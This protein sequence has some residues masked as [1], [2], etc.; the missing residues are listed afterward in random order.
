MNYRLGAFG[1]LAG[2][3]IVKGRGS[4]NLGWLDQTL[5]MKWVQKNIHL[6][7]GDPGLV[8]VFGE[9]AGASSILHHTTAYGGRGPSPPF[10]R[11]IPQSPA[12]FPQPEPSQQE[13]AYEALLVE[14][15]V[16]TSGELLA[17]NTSSLS[18]ANSR[19][20]RK[21]NY[22]QFI[23]GPTVDLF[24]N[25]VLPAQAL[26]GGH[27]FKEIE[28]MT[29]YNQREGL[30]FTPPYVQSDSSFGAYIQK[31]L[32]AASS[33]V[34]VQIEELYPTPSYSDS[35]RGGEPKARIDRLSQA[36]GDVA[37]NCNTYY[38]HQA[39]KKFT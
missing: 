11:A 19:T 33:D 16:E 17:L 5:A 30:L 35:D 15:G 4:T 2:S 24:I 26:M 39:V 3:G 27:F 13:A 10:K 9:S 22:G 20:I 38:L 8:T 7:G 25:S 32:P 37:V 6:F 36:L 31:A 12:F 18:T 1:W 23:F 29:A 21:S 34:I 28:I 14:A